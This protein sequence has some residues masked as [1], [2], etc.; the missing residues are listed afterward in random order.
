MTG[1]FYEVIRPGLESVQQPAPSMAIADAYLAWLRRFLPCLFL[2][3]LGCAPTDAGQTD[4][5]DARPTHDE[6]ALGLST[7]GQLPQ[8]ATASDSARFWHALMVQHM[9]MVREVTRENAELRS[10]APMLQLGQL[11]DE[12]DY[13]R[14]R[15][16]V[17]AR[18]ES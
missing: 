1:P 16:G 4:A 14:A 12:N 2:L 8:T 11:E 5:T 18:P 15:C 17:P 10:H 3:L 6:L 13:L 7:D 9:Q